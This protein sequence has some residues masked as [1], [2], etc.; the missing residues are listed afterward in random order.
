MAN[1]KARR[2]W[3]LPGAE[4]TVPKS[5]L[6]HGGDE[7]LVNLPCPS[8]LIEH[9]KGLALFDTG[10]NPKIID[11]PVGYWGEFARNLPFKWSKNETLDRQIAGLGYK[12]SDIKYVVLSHAHLDH[13][14]GLTYFPGAKFL[15]GAG[16]L[17]YA[18]WPDPDRRWAFILDDYVPT[19]GSHRQFKHPTK[20]GCVT[21]AEKPSDDLAPGTLNSI[22]KQAQIKR[23]H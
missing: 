19:R 4:L 2:M 23:G 1:G 3:V 10:C 21:V 8:F 17:R 9:P 5:L 14:G 7:T 15:V 12:T 16:E 22:L 13:A 20:V 18:Y 6:M 11:D